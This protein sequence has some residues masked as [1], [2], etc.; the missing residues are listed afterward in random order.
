MLINVVEVRM[1]G[2]DFAGHAGMVTIGAP[3]ALLEDATNARMTIKTI[4]CLA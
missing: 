2:A 4:I 1:E 3:L